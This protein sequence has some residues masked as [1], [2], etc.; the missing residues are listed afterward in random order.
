MRQKVEADSGYR[1]KEEE[2][3]EEY[4]TSTVCIF[5]ASNLLEMKKGWLRK[6]CH[7]CTAN[8]KNITHTIITNTSVYYIS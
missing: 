3:L 6:K 4:T 2:D 8:H 1:I 7:Y 5:E